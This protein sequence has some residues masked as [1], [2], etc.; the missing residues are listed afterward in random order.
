VSGTLARVRE[1]VLRGKY[2]LS[3]HAYE[4]AR[5]DGILPMDIINGVHE[6]EVVEDYPNANRGPSVL[7]LSR[8]EDGQPIHAVWGIHR[9]NL[10]KAVVITAYKPEQSLWST[11]FLNRVKP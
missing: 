10:Y 11:D 5:D 1:L 3:D 4:A 6:A 7:I 9:D 2:T 8:N